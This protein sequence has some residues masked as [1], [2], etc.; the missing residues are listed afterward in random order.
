MSNDGYLISNLARPCQFKRTCRPKVAFPILLVPIS[1][2]DSPSISLPSMLSYASY[3]K[4]NQAID[5]II[6]IPVIESRYTK[7]ISADEVEGEVGVSVLKLSDQLSL[8]T[9]TI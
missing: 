9:N 4:V 1:E 6:R 7:G 5:S 8:S 3:R 2:Q